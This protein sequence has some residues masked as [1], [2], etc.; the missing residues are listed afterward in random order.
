MGES[1]YSSGID[2]DYLDFESLRRAEIAGGA[3]QIA[4]ESY[5]VVVIPNMRT[6][7]GETIQ[8][9]CA[10]AQAGGKVICVGDFPIFS[11]LALEGLEE[12]DVYKRQPHRKC[13]R[14]GAPEESDPGGG[15][16]HGLYPARREGPGAPIWRFEGIR[17]DRQRG[18]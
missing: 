4:G 1:L 18:T 3:L 17:A 2:L 7:R 10:F 9:L 11:D 15:I 12:E 5:S 6:I 13:P 8:K 14:V 16:R